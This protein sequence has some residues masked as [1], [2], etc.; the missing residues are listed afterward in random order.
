MSAGRSWTSRTSAGYVLEWA[1]FDGH[2]TACALGAKGW[3]S[4]AEAQAS[5]DRRSGAIVW[6]APGRSSST[7]H[8]FFAE[9]GDRKQSIRAVSIDMS[10]IPA[11]HPRRRPGRRNLFS[12]RFMS[13]ASAPAPPTRSAGRVERP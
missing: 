7:S 9:L 3:C 6:G 13:C 10:G 5:A 12:T 2:L 1:R 8:G 4:L 11:R